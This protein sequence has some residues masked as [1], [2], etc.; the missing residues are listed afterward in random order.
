MRNAC[1]KKKEHMSKVKVKVTENTKTTIWAITSEPEVVETSGWF[2]NVPCQNIYQK[3]RSPHDAWRSVFASHDVNS[4]PIDF[5][6]GKHI[7]FTCT[8][9]HIKHC[10]NKNNITRITMATKY[11]IIKHRAFFQNLNRG[12][13]PIHIGRI[14]MKLR[15][16][17]FFKINTSCLQTTTHTHYIPMCLLLKL[18]S[19]YILYGILSATIIYK[20]VQHKLTTN[21]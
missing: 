13:S 2:Q 8:I 11:P 10:T 21:I 16:W 12:I 1:D 9:Y 4:E 14:P 3:C 5:K 20:D 7:D 17:N 19:E 18:P 15:E 6:I